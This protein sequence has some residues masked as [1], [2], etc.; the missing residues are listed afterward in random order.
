LSPL[1][2]HAPKDRADKVSSPINRRYHTSKAI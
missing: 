1:L 2:Q